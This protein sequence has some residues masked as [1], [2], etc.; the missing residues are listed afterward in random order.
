MKIFYINTIVLD[1]DSSIFFY[2]KLIKEE[3]TYNAKYLENYAITLF[4]SS[5]EADYKNGYFSL[6][7][8]ENFKDYFSMLAGMEPYIRE[9][10][11]SLSYVTNVSGIKAFMVVISEKSPPFPYP[12]VV[13]KDNYRLVRLV[14]VLTEDRD[15]DA[16]FFHV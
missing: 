16:S 1:E 15:A 13:I 9:V 5:S 10:W 7:S 14:D 3:V 2:F 6:W 11:A 8:S 12:F 4:I